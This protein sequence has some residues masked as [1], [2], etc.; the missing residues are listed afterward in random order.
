[1]D[2]SN[3][4]PINGS[5]A[6]NAQEGFSIVGSTEFVSVAGVKNLPAK[7]DTG[8]D[9][10]AIW[11]SNIDMRAD[12][13]LSF[14]LFDPS[15]PFYTGETLTTT[16]YKARVVRSSNGHEQIRYL[17]SLPLE[18]G[19]K[20][21]ETS[22]SLAD[23]SKNRFPILIGRKTLEGNFLVDVSIRHA[24]STKN[25]KTTSLNEELRKNPYEF[26]KKYVKTM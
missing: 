15:S 16:S 23:R 4:T 20:T 8:A 19:G 22:F 5:P 13:V 6:L 14:T 3:S 12:G 1:M 21:L 7:I 18:L 9:S 11:A 10:S 2:K 26:H 25:V 17:V 24:K